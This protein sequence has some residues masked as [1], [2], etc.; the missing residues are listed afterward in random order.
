MYFGMSQS[1]LVDG[2]A[3]VS[4]WRLTK[5]R[6]SSPR[7]RDLSLAETSVETGA[8]TGGVPALQQPGPTPFLD[9]ANHRTRA[10]AAVQP[11]S[12]RVRFRLD[13]GSGKVYCAWLHD[14]VVYLTT[15]TAVAGSGGAEFYTHGVEVASDRPHTASPGSRSGPRP[16]R[17]AVQRLNQGIVDVP[18]QNMTYPTV[19]MN[20]A[21]D[22]VIGVTLVGPGAYPSA[23][24]IPFTTAGRGVDVEIAGAGVGPN[25]GFTGHSRSAPTAPGGATTARPTSLPTARCGSRTSTSRND[26]TFATFHA[27]P[28]CGFTRSSFANW[29]TRVSAYNPSSGHHGEMRGPA[30]RAP[31]SR[32]GAMFWFRWNRLSGS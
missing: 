32:Y 19:A 31:S 18:G 25:D 27:D 4:L 11:A 24:Y 15:A 30:S 5:P 8:Y 13:G 26:A 20:A 29:S 10:S 28:T 12:V 2:I 22:G 1:P 3:C 21:G 7:R 23:A 14:G 16:P 9:C 17:T 6:R